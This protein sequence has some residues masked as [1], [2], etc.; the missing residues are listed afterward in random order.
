MIEVNS[1]LENGLEVWGA[2]EDGSVEI[3]SIFH[4]FITLTKKD[5]L[6]L[7]ELSKNRSEQQKQEPEA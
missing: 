6:D 2:S 7:L 4:D 3:E 1:K 5:L